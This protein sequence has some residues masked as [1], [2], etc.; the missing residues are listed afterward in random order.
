M[1]PTG[2]VTRADFNN[3][4]PTAA[5]STPVG[6]MPSLAVSMSGEKVIRDPK[7]RGE[8]GWVVA[9]KDREEDGPVF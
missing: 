3:C 5:R 7:R 4:R 8:E 1:G 6:V 2:F 9:E